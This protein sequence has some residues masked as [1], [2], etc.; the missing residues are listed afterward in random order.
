MI[1]LQYTTIQIPLPD[2]IYEGLK[3]FCRNANV[4][5]PQPPELIEP[6]A[7][8]FRLEKQNIFLTV[9]ADEAIQLFAKIYGKNAYVFTPTYIVYQDVE[10]FGGKLNRIYSLNSHSKFE[11]NPRPYQD[12]T[13]I[14]LANPNNPSGFTPKKEVISLVENNPQ[15]I[16]VIDEAYGDFADISVINKINHYSNLAVIRS[17][18]KSYGMAGNRVGFVATANHEV[19][20][21][22]GR[23]AQ[24]CNVSYLSVGAA[25]AALN[26]EDYFLKIREEIKEIRTDFS[27][28]LIKAGYQIIPSLINAQLIK[29]QSEVEAKSFVAFLKKHEI[30]VN[31]GNGFSNI[32]LDNSF[33]R[34]AIGTPAQME[35]VKK[36]IAEFKSG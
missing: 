14:Y 7:R 16:V 19:R 30:I 23:F 27:N 9:G 36:I 1:N 18:S 28:F 34:I 21:K 12:G 10:V 11:I 24:W 6:I 29:F 32:G 35:Q 31:Q 25:V 3:S 5:H 26:H 15:A 8:K 13:L 17:F 20:K 22:F 2:F 4:Y 33:V